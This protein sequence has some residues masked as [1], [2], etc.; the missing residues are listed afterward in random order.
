MENKNLQSRAARGD[1]IV[2]RLKAES[3][4][5]AKLGKPFIEIHRRFQAAADVADKAEDARDAALA[6]VNG[7]DKV[8][9]VSIF[10]LADGCVAAKLGTRMKPFAGLSPFAPSALVEL[11]YARQLVEVRKLSAAI[12]KKKPSGPLAKALAVVDKNANAVEAAL[13]KLSVPQKKYGDAL[14]A[15]DALLPEWEKQLRS[16]E[17][18]VAAELDDDIAAAA[19]VAPASD[20]QVPRKKRASKKKPA[21][22]TP[23]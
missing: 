2:E 10:G 19:L 12:K 5:I 16:L 1:A 21:A 4:T 20:V 17:R 3:A 15:R 7:A 11:G 14:A 6:T 23:A 9:D 22:P 18:K 8:L 13:K